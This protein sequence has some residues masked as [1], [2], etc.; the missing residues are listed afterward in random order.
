MGHG[1]A[2]QPVAEFQ[3]IGI[4]VRE[5]GSA[6][7]VDLLVAQMEGVAQHFGAGGALGGFFGGP[8]GAKLGS[9]LS[10][11]SGISHTYYF[12]RGIK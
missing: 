3:V 10:R 7:I 8:L 12:W 5:V 11:C 9:E 1:H 6:E 2:A 4:Q